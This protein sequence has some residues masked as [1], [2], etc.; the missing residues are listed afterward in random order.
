[1]KIRKHTN[2]YFTEADMHMPNKDIGKYPV[3]LAFRGK[4]IK[5]IT[6]NYGPYVY[7]N[8]QLQKG[9]SA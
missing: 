9:D 4:K 5:A 3:S 6:C 7:F 8:E 1:M 2:R